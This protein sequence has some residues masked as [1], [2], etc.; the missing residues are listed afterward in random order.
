MQYSAVC[1]F[2][3]FAPAST[4]FKTLRSFDYRGLPARVTNHVQNL[5]KNGFLACR[6]CAGHIRAKDQLGLQERAH[7]ITSIP[8]ET[9]QDELPLLQALAT[10][11]LTQ[12]IF[13]LGLATDFGNTVAIAKHAQPAARLWFE[14][15]NISLPNAD[16]G[17][18]RNG[19]DLWAWPYATALTLD[20]IRSRQTGNGHAARVMNYVVAAADKF[21]VT[22]LGT[23]EAHEVPG[24]PRTLTNEQLYAWYERIGFLR[25][26]GLQAN[27][28]V[29]QPRVD[30]SQEERDA[31]Y[32][33]ALNALTGV[34][35]RNGL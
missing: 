25:Q 31:A 12:E 7:S 33:S 18:F 10:A 28:I 13:W 29:R 5:V 22:L 1:V 35:A 15:L 3:R 9:H 2:C 27:A 32:M 8:V 34:T 20:E 23:V 11:A 17:M 21:N 14:I 30:L 26:V 16:H 4:G 24:T 6:D 19:V